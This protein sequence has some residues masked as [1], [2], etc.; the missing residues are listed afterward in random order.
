M[1]PYLTSLHYYEH[2]VTYQFP[3]VLNNDATI[4]VTVMQMFPEENSHDAI[5]GLKVCNF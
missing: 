3:T 2:L 4:F 1:H 5:S